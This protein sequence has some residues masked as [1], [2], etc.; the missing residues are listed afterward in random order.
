MLLDHQKSRY[1]SMSRLYD[2]CD[3]RFKI[4]C[5]LVSFTFPTTLRPVPLYW[6]SYQQNW[7]CSRR[8]RA[9]CVVEEGTKAQA[10]ALGPRA[11][12]SSR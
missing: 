10:L 1:R 5:S 12:K 2:Q 8:R 6:E 3:R 7:F 9:R 11:A 4:A